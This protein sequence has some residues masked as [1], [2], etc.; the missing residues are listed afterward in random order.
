[1][2]PDEAF[3]QLKSFFTEREAA[4]V[5]LGK[6]RENVEIEIVIGGMVTCALFRQGADIRVEKRSAQ[7]PDFIFRL[8]P[9]TVTILA[10]QTRDDIADIGLAIIKEMLA[11]SIKVEMPGGLMTVLR[12]GYIDVVF[13]GGAPIT[14]KLGQIGLSS[15]LKIV[16]LFRSLRR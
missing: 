2:T 4:R 9:Q 5:S 12:D 3:L 6:L 7:K 16:D 8:E 14:A 10:H 11:G 1:M 13:S 15:P